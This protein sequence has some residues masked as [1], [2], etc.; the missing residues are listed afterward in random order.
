MN[1]KSIITTAALAILISPAIAGVQ[2]YQGSTRWSTTLFTPSISTMAATSSYTTY[3]IFETSG[4]N[5]VDALRID[6]W[7]T[8]FGRFYYIDESFSADYS[9]FGPFGNDVAGGMESDD[10]SAILPFRGK[11]R[12]GIL[13]SFS[14]YRAVDYYTRNGNVDI[15]TITGSARLNTYFSGNISLNRAANE[16]LDYL[17]SRGFY[18]Y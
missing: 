18:E 8:T 6:A 14:L 3:Y 15:S 12:Y 1:I 16:V 9:Y 11:L 5:V 17:E 13:D 10:V 4:G 7:T 2:T